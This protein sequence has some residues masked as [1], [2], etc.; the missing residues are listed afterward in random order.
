MLKKSKKEK[1]TLI[2]MFCVIVSILAIYGSLRCLE[3]IVMSWFN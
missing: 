2:D 1:I 3:A